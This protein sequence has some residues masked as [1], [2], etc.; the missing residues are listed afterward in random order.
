MGGQAG[1]WPDEVIQGLDEIKQLDP[2]TGTNSI[3]VHVTY[4][5]STTKSSFEAGWTFLNAARQPLLGASAR[6]VNVSAM[7]R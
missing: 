5:W 7:G 6:R 3:T 1:E 2:V 4:S